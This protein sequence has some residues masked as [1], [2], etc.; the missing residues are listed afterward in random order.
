MVEDKFSSV[1][2]D[3]REWTIEMYYMN[4]RVSTKLGLLWEDECTA[5]VAYDVFMDTFEAMPP[6]AAVEHATTLLEYD[7]EAQLRY[8]ARLYNATNRA[9]YAVATWPHD[10]MH[11]CALDYT[12][13]KLEDR[14]LLVQVLLPAETNND[15][16][17][18]VELAE[19]GLIK[20]LDTET[21]ND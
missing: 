8:E 13:Q 18:W 10:I 2:G 6:L 21:N 1:L 4:G 9:P 12:E 3:E 7:P 11:E 20:V 19:A 15:E 17:D 14:N 5:G 16:I